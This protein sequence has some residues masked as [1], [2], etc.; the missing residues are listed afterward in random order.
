MQLL[1]SLDLRS[2]M[3]AGWGL[4]PADGQ[5]HR[6][7]FWFRTCPFLGGLTTLLEPV[8]LPMVRAMFEGRLLQPYVSAVGSDE[9]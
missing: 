4:G 9:G 2:P 6:G 8:I 1:C 3:A 5:S 7:C